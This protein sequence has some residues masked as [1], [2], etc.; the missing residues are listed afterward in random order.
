L[1]INSKNER[2][3]IQH[4]REWIEKLDKDLDDIEKDNSR[5]NYN[6]TKN[7]FNNNNNDNSNLNLNYNKKNE[8]TSIIKFIIFFSIKLDKLIIISR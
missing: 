6:N 4:G 2:E 7:N 1:N 3:K 5:I 8:Y